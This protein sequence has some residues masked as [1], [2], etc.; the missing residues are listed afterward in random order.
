MILKL[1]QHGFLRTK[2]FLLIIK[3]TIFDTDDWS[4]DQ[5]SFETIYKKFDTVTFDRFSTNLNK[6]SNF[7]SVWNLRCEL[8]Y[9]ELVR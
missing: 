2:I 8:L 5:N 4:L 3:V 7:N 1:Y 6:V 9:K